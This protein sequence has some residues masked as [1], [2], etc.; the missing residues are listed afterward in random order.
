[1]PRWGGIKRW[2]CLTSVWRLS[3]CL[4]RTSGL[5]GEQRGLWRLK[6]AQRQPTSHVTRTPFSRSK[7]QRSRSR[8]M[9]G[10]LYSLLPTACYIQWLKRYGTQGNAVTPP[11]FYS[12]WR[13]AT[14]STL[15]TQGNGKW[16]LRYANDRV[17]TFC[18]VNNLT[19]KRW[20]NQFHDAKWLA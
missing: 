4:W 14:S 9:R 20:V 8:A 18:T 11:P 3:V 12:L 13:F 16:T 19:V 1:M 6:L 10:I 2:C 17:L 15:K 7:A 5:S